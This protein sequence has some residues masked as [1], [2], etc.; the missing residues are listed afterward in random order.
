[1]RISD[2]SSDVCSSDLGFT[3][4]P[5]HANQVAPRKRPFHTIIPGFAMDLNGDPLMAFGLMGGPIQAQGHLQLALRILGYGQNPQA[6]ADAPRWRIDSGRRVGVEPG[7][8]PSLIEDRKSTRLN[9][10]H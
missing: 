3:L 4:E 5:G 6:A 10:S 8:D 9:S 7:T 2:W 1:M